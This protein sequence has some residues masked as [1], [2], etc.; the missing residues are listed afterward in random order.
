MQCRF[1]MICS[2]LRFAESLIFDSQPAQ[3]LPPDPLF[4]SPSPIIS[5]ADMQQDSET[6]NYEAGP[7]PSNVNAV[8]GSSRRAGATPRSA[9]RT[10]LTQDE[11]LQRSETVHNRLRD[12]RGHKKVIKDYAS[13]A[14]RHRAG[15]TATLRRAPPVDAQGHFHPQHQDSSS[16]T[17][18]N[19]PLPR[20][21]LATSRT[22]GME[23]G[24]PH[25]AAPPDLLSR[26]T[27]HM[28]YTISRLGEFV[29]NF[30]AG[31]PAPVDGAAPGEDRPAHGGRPGLHL[32]QIKRHASQ[33]WQRRHRNSTGA[34]LRHRACTL[35]F[36]L[37]S[38][39]A[40][41]SCCSGQG[42]SGVHP[43]VGQW[44][45]RLRRPEPPHRVAAAVHRSRARHLGPVHPTRV[46][47]RFPYQRL[48]PLTVPSLVLVSFGDEDNRTSEVVAVRAPT[49]LA[50]GKLHALHKLYRR[51]V[52]D[53]ISVDT[54][55]EE[56]AA[57]IKG[58]PEYSAKIRLVLAF[59]CS[60]IICPMSFN[61][62]FLD[63]LMSGLGGALLCFMQH[64]FIVNHPM[65]A[66]VFECVAAFSCIC[67]PR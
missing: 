26:T 56:I 30:T 28:S 14:P 19:T 44:F 8:A 43:Q 2:G 39:A 33:L 65:Y 24:I 59:A 18:V 53:E 20:P 48:T 10:Y 29:A 37:R 36:A 13:S 23:E 21:M 11:P 55:N 50:L 52:H 27:T 38:R 12:K 45:A 17:L 22:R 31:G 62:S 49:K 67:R 35:A 25:D 5:H 58:P 9:I 6:R 41:C 51:V 46:V 63:M 1:G 61:G 34:I 7:R 32:G 60:A 57:I 40:D 4:L 47:P 3:T 54:A 64:F 42:S 15:S 66:S 16:S